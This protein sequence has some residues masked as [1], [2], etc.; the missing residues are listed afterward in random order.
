MYVTIAEFNDKIRNF[1]DDNDRATGD[2]K[3]TIEEYTF[4]LEK[5]LD[6]LEYTT[7]NKVKL[8]AYAVI[9]SALNS[10]ANDFKSAGISKNRLENLGSESNRGLS[11]LSF[12]NPIYKQAKDKCLASLSIAMS[13]VERAYSNSSVGGK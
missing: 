1:K 6:N 9:Q 10:S 7:S 11:A 13:R 3:N 5:L 8:N 4:S 12:E 2:V